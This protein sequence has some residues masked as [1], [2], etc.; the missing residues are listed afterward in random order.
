MAI[1]SIKGRLS[2]KNR[3]A[4]AGIELEGGWNEHPPS[5]V[6]HDGSVKIPQPST[7]KMPTFETNEAAEV[8]IKAERERLAKLTMIAIGEVVSPPIP[9]EEASITKFI[10]DNYPTRVNDTCGLHVHMSF[11]H[12]LNYQRLMTPDFTKAMVEGLKVWAAQEGLKETHP[13]L[14]R[15]YDAN[16][17]H[18][19]HVYCG[20]AQSMQTSKDFRSRGTAHSRYTAINYC[21][22]QHQTVECRLLAMMDTPEQATRAVLEVLNITNRLLAK[23]RAKELKKVVRVPPANKT[24]SRFRVTV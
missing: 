23:V 2:P 4:L 5:P 17:P 1:D 18:C 21:Y 22:S 8:W 3:I 11:T 10:A 16:H 7:K 12:K 19:A 14:A 15:L 24:V 9:A 13:L 20:E 6:V